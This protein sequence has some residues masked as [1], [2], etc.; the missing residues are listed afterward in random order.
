MFAVTQPVSQSL[1]NCMAVKT[2]KVSYSLAVRHLVLEAPAMMATIARASSTPSQGT[3][4]GY[5]SQG[6]L[7]VLPQYQPRPV[8]LIA[9]L[10]LVSSQT[11]CSL[12]S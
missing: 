11:Q 12:Q 4:L 2:S 7:Y 8:A 5:K 3:G 10:G 1:V 9:L 6:A